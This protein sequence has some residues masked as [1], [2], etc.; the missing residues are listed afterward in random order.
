MPDA[1][2]EKGTRKREKDACLTRAR[3]VAFLDSRDLFLAYFIF[4]PKGG[5]PLL[6]AS[7][8]DFALTLPGKSEI[9][10]AFAFCFLLFFVLGLFFPLKLTLSFLFLSF[11]S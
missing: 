6:F 4:F 11:F 5:R 10:F 7:W 8:L 3:R 1:S 9:F 2:V